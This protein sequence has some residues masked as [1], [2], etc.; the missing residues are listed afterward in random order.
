[1]KKRTFAEGGSTNLTMI[2][3]RVVEPFPFSPFM[4]TVG[5]GGSTGPQ[6][7]GSGTAR[8]GLDTV[9]QGAKTVSGALDDIQARIGGGGGLGS[10]VPSPGMTGMKKGGAVKGYAKG[11]MV[12][13]ASRRA[14]GIAQRGKTKGRML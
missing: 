7:S 3:P 11:G 14:D 13:A 8:G 12:G 2:D 1:M 9:R 6:S 4:P 5:D 10:M